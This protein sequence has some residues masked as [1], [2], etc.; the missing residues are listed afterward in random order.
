MPNKIVELADR[1]EAQLRVQGVEVISEKPDNTAAIAI[2]LGLLT[3]L[4]LNSK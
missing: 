2:G 4:L 3:A 1:Y